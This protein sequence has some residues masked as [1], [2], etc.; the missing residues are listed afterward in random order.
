MFDV[1]LIGNNPMSGHKQTRMAEGQ[2]SLVFHPA[3]GDKNGIPA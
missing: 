3:K 1:M 2:K